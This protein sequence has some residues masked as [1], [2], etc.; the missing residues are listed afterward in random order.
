M[1][2]TPPKSNDLFKVWVELFDVKGNLVYT[3]KSPKGMEVTPEDW[4]RIEERIQLKEL[5]KENKLGS[6]I[7]YES[8][9]DVEYWQGHFGAQFSC[10]SIKLVCNQNNDSICSMFP[11]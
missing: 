11:V 4:T 1:K 9:R 6:L 10:E 5:S 3:N 7:L 8:G 2:G